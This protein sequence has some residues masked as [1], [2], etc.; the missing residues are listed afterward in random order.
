MNERAP[1]MREAP[2]M[3]ANL[4]Y[5]ASHSQISCASYHETM[6]YTRSI[7]HISSDVVDELGE[8]LPLLITSQLVIIQIEVEQGQLQNGIAR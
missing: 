7:A 1:R 4:H 6:Q 3:Q 2:M 5:L 8:T